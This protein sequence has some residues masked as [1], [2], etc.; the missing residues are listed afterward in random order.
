MP[1]KDTPGLRRLVAQALAAQ[2][3]VRVRV[4]PGRHFHVVGI[5]DYGPGEIFRLPRLR[6]RTLIEANVVELMPDQPDQ[7]ARPS[8]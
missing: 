8:A 6:A 5:R 4:L 3:E 1:F 7:P 2:D